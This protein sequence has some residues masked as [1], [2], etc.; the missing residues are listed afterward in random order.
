LL[1]WC[2][3]IPLGWK[4][5]SYGRTPALQFWSPELISQSHQK[6]KGNF[7]MPQRP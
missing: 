7:P 3:T 6:K 2:D 5:G 4:Y 1:I